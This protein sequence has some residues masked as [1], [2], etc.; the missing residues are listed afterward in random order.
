[1]ARLDAQRLHCSWE[2]R[3]AAGDGGPR[4]NQGSARAARCFG[5]SGHRR[6]C[7]LVT[8][9]HPIRAQEKLLERRVAVGLL[10]NLMP[11]A[12]SR[13]SLAELTSG[14]PHGYNST[15]ISILPPRC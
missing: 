8:F 9:A 15:R 13:A 11:S 14:G 10:R 4:S 1:M 12:E 2:F 5:G 7:P 6:I 3:P